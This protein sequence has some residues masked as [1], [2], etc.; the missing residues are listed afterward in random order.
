MGDSWV[1]QGLPC[2]HED[3]SSSRRT[4][5]LCFVF[6]GVVCFVLKWDVVVCAYDPSTEQDE[7]GDP[8][9]LLGSQPGLLAQ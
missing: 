7:I 9:D 4:H 8:G 2:K 3:L 5:V 1:I 6:L